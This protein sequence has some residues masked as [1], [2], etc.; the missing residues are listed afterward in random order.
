MIYN[1]SKTH[2]HINESNNDYDYQGYRKTS[3]ISW[4]CNHRI[5]LRD[6]TY[7]KLINNEYQL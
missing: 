3:I 5:T 6:D 7:I 4:E 1:Q 2:R